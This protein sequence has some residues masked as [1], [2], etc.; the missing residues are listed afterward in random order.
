MNKMGLLDILLS[1]TTTHELLVSEQVLNQKQQ[2]TEK[3]R[4]KGKENDA[5]KSNIQMEH[6]HLL[7]IVLEFT[8]DVDTTNIEQTLTKGKGRVQ[9]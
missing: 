2:Q 6:W 8:V 3:D 5:A 1:R 4:E 9:P 7:V